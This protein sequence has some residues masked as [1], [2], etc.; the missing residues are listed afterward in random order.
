[1]SDKKRISRWVVV[2]ILLFQVGCTSGPKPKAVIE[3]DSSGAEFDWATF[4]A[5][6]EL[7]FKKGSDDYRMHL[8]DSEFPGDIVT[9]EV[10]GGRAVSAKRSGNMYQSMSER[11]SSIDTIEKIFAVVESEAKKKSKVFV[12]FGDEGYPQYVEAKNVSDTSK[13]LTISVSGVS[14]R[15]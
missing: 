9:I 4:N 7:W 3:Y 15:R 12:R 1:M 8:Q 11:F 5:N 10:A 2:V 14:I 13:G 6:K